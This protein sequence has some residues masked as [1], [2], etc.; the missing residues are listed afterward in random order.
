MALLLA[1]KFQVLHIVQDRLIFAIL[2]YESNLVDAGG[3][4]APGACRLKFI[5]ESKRSSLSKPV[6]NSSRLSAAV[7]V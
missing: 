6:G 3:T 7:E 4:P 5:A 2:D 1:Q